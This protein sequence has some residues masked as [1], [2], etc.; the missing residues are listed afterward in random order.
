MIEQVVNQTVCGVI[1]TFK[2]ELML[3]QNWWY[4][5][6]VI[7]GWLFAQFWRLKGMGDYR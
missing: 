2:I 7:T 1:M 5:F 6:G 3:L 4:L